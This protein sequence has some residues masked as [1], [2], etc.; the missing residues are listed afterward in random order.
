[1][2]SIEYDNNGPLLK[3]VICFTKAKKPPESLSIGLHSL[4]ILEAVSY[5][6]PS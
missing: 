2:K 3:Q 1:M 4:F 6:L 5:I